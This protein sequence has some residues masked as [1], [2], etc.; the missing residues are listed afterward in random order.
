MKFKLYA[1]TSGWDS[2]HA[3]IKEYLGIPTGSTTEYAVRSVI[4]NPDNA[5][6][7]KYPFIVVDSGRWKCDD[8]F[9]AKDLV[10][11]DPT[12]ELPSLPA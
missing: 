1:S 6:F 10:D 7:G 4:N 9:N 3:S 11:Y 12:W 5:D 2:R 8:Q